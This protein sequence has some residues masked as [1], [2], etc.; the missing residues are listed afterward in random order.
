MGLLLLELAAEAGIIQP[1]PE[2]CTLVPSDRPAVYG[3]NMP[4]NTFASFAGFAILVRCV[5]N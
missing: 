4:R 1:A 3:L 5:V 2:T